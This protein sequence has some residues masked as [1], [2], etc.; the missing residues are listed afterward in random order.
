MTSI[1]TNVAAMTALQTLQATNKMM[2][3]NQTRISTGYRVANAKDN[4]AYW[5]IA[6]TMRSDNQA[7]SAVKDSLGIGAA[8]VDTAYTALDSAKD[9]LNEIKA[10]LTTATQDGVD[11]TKVQDEISQLQAQLKSIADSASFSGQNWLSIDTSSGTY[12]FHKPV[13]SNLSRDSSGALSI[14]TI[15]VDTSKLALFDA[16]TANSS[17]ILNGGVGGNT[18]ANGVTDGTNT[19]ATATAATVSMGSATTGLTLDVNDTIK[20]DVAIGTGTTAKVLTIDQALVNSTLGVTDGKIAGATAMASV[21]NAALTAAG[22]A[23]SAT[24]S[25]AG[26]LSLSTTAT[27]T[28]TTITVSNTDADAGTAISE[29]D[30]TD[31]SISSADIK[32]LLNAVDNAISKVTAGASTLGAIQNRIDMQTTF[33]SNLMDTISGGIG[34]LVDADM[35]EESTKLKALQTQQQLGVQAL[36]IA[37][38]SSEAVLQLFKG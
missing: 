3:E 29:I 16:N 12:N 14:G 20:F 25:T 23:A 28:G 10:K 6:T 7:M 2:E 4:A 13:V 36:S 9:V 31:P 33:V 1:I 8:T 22:V 34:T 38:S 18:S 35:T 11:R 26:A 24:A 5:S 27:G 37:N 30:I 21:M 19:A 17:A 32:R 15:T